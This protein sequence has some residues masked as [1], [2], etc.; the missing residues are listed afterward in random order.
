MW[1]GTFFMMYLVCSL[2]HLAQNLN[3][4]S[5]KNKSIKYFLLAVIL[6]IFLWMLLELYYVKIHP[7]DIHIAVISLL[8]I[9]LSGPLFFKG[10][11]NVALNFN[12]SIL[13][14]ALCTVANFFIAIAFIINFHFWIGGTK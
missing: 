11:R 5:M 12:K 1:R 9:F 2:E 13:L 14:S 10:F 3:H 6:P 7:I 8:F 4:I